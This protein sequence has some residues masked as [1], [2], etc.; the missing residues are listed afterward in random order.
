MEQIITTLNKV[1]VG[2]IVVESLK[3]SAE[4][5]AGLVVSILREDEVKAYLEIIKKQGSVP[6]YIR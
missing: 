6:G 2:A 5:L 4:A 3:E 1:Q